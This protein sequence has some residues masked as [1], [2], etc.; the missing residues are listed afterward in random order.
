MVAHPNNRRR[1]INVDLMLAQSRRRWANIKS[2]LVQRL[3]FAG[4]CDGI[5]QRYLVGDRNYTKVAYILN[6]N[7]SFV[8]PYYYFKAWLLKIN[9]HFPNYIVTD[10]MIWF[11][12]HHTSNQIMAI[13]CTIQLLIHVIIFNREPLWP[14]LFSILWKQCGQDFKVKIKFVTWTIIMQCLVFYSCYLYSCVNP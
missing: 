6:K 10:I 1:W 2:T 8:L 11:F 12:V 14:S 9:Y 7:L 5:C 3:V 13:I 4:S